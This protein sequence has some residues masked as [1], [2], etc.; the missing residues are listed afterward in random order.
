MGADAYAGLEPAGVWRH[1][2]ELNA[3]PRPSGSE[4][5]ARDHVQQLTTAAG[6]EWV[7]DARGNAIAR[8]AA[9]DGSSGPTV[10]VQAHLDMVCERSPEATTD[11]ASDGVVP[12][13]DGDR[14]YGEGTTLGADN[15][16]GVAAALALV[17][18]PGIRHG[19]LELIFTLDEESGL[20][21]A[22]ELDTSLLRAEALI[23]LD[24]EDA[25]ALTIGCAGGAE[26]IVRLPV[27]REGFG[28]AAADLRITGLAGGH[29]G[30]QIHER[31]ANAVKL[32]VDVL[33]RAQVASAGARLVRVDGGTAHNAIPREATVGLAFDA[34]SAARVREALRAAA[35]EVGDEWR[36]AEPGLAIEVLEVDPGAPCLEPAAADALLALLRGLPHGVIAMSE[37]FE[38]TVETSA[39]LATVATRDGDVEVLVSVRS[40]KDAEIRD[41]QKGIVDLAARAGGSADIADGYP[42]WEPREGSP[43]L[44]ATEAAYERVYGREPRI[45]VVHGGLECGVIVA[46]KPGLDAISFG[47]TIVNPHTP[48]EHVYASTVATTWRLLL[49]L[50]GELAVS[51]R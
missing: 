17:T 2:S 14:I 51:A 41:V 40:L 20:R 47:P 31:R 39:N 9:T 3:I 27:R 16:I 43:L 30:I 19:P 46:H 33:G 28:D 8:V 38:S 32:A 42:G 12:R 21:G 18:E 25:D 4:Q 44:A 5:A 6:A 34:L 37:R 15:G 10:A 26:A 29:S 7:T 45:D 24:S 48:D 1:F 50:L 23:N 35:A 11:P 13:R 36:D 22:L 49:E